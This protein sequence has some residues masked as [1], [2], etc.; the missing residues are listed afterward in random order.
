MASNR[1]NETTAVKDT[2]T[3]LSG[4]S[5]KTALEICRSMVRIRLSQ[6]AL[7]REYLEVIA[8]DKN[9]GQ[10]TELGLGTQQL[11]WAH[12]DI[13]DEKILGTAHVATGRSDH[14]GGDISSANFKNKSNATHNDILFTPDKTPD[15]ELKRVT[16]RRD[17]KETVIVED[18]Q[19]SAFIEA[20]L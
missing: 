18:Y 13:Q 17:G 6:E 16:M 4:V 2:G 5:R 8:F 15:V 14:L 3:S 10:L 12:T 9:A 20:L 19:P 11:P 7:I 1:K